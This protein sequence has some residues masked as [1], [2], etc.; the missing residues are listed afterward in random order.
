VLT[1]HE[2]TPREMRE[3][4]DDLRPADEYRDPADENDLEEDHKSE[5]EE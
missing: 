1:Q 2:K 3:M 4:E 5:D